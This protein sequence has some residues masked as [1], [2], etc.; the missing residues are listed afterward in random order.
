MFDI[1]SAAVSDRVV[2][3]LLTS[4]VVVYIVVLVSSALGCSIVEH[5]TT[6]RPTSSL[7]TVFRQSKENQIQRGRKRLP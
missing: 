6:A 3:P 4:L 1:F 7:G 5:N 2:L